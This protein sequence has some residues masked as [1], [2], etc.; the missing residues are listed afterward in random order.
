MEMLRESTECAEIH[1]VL[2]VYATVTV[3][4]GIVAAPQDSTVSSWAVVVELVAR[5]TEALSTI[6]T[7]GLPLLIRQGFGHQNV[8]VD[9]NDVLRHLA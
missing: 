5:I 1:F 8:V 9:R 7:D 4:N 3:V 2:R 6:P